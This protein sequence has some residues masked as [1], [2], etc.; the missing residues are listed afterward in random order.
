MDKRRVGGIGKRK[1]GVSD[2][3]TDTQRTEPRTAQKRD[4]GE[5]KELRRMRNNVSRQ[6]SRQAPSPALDAG[7]SSTYPTLPSNTHATRMRH[8]CRWQSHPMH[9]RATCIRRKKGCRT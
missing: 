2:C 6:P 1:A 4:G 7:V 5:G 8:Q 9:E 3:N